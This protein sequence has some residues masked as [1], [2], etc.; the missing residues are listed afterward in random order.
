MINNVNTS[1]DRVIFM[2]DASLSKEEADA[3]YETSKYVSDE[4]ISWGTLENNT[5]K[6][7][8]EVMTEDDITLRV[9][10]WYSLMGT[11]RYGFCLLYKNAIP[12]RRWDDKAGH[13]DPC[14]NTILM[15]AHKHYY[16]PE[17]DD[18]CAY[19]TNDVRLH[20]VNGALMDFLK[21][22]HISLGNSR[23]QETIDVK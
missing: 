16:C 1:S 12:I 22:C 10:G 21:E 18:A 7:N 4:I 17:Y 5:Q 6:I 3:L 19:E 11:K 2:L 13:P 15:K 23:Y 8:F 9:A 14:T 20:D